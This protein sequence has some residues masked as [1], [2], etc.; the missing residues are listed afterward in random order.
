M[1]VDTISSDEYETRLQDDLDIEVTVEASSI[2]FTASD[3][4]SKEKDDD[5]NSGVIPG[6]DQASGYILI[7]AGAVVILAASIIGAICYKRKRN[8]FTS[9]EA[10]T[11]ET[12]LE[13]TARLGTNIDAPAQTAPKGVRVES[14]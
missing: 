5:D 3:I 7:S 13:L 9:P 11:T 4:G 12:N 1:I 14:F 10:P 8:P 2:S 6:V